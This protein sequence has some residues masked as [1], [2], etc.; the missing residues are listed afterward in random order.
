MT[1]NTADMLDFCKE[2]NV[3]IKMR[4]W[5]G[6]MLVRITRYVKL[7]KS[8]K[9]KRRFHVQEMF[10]GNI[11]D[12]VFSFNLLKMAEKLKQD[13]IDHYGKGVV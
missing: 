12:D 11:S 2:N 1:Y 5:M 8:L 13:L 6:Y 9:S 7:E 3:E 4:Y 10:D